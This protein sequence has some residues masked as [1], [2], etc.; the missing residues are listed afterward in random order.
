MKLVLLLKSNVKGHYRTTKSG[1]RVFVK[2][3]D[4][5]RVRHEKA[6]KKTKEIA[7]QMLAKITKEGMVEIPA[8]PS[9]AIEEAI[10][11]FEKT[12]RYEKSEV[13]GKSYLG[14]KQVTMFI[15]T[16]MSEAK[17]QGDVENLLYWSD[18]HWMSKRDSMR[19]WSLPKLIHHYNSTNEKNNISVER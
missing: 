15:A 16:R 6:P 4:D 14:P 12:G 18:L 2:P 5:S 17:G 11:I 7:S 19:K 1:K 3:H 8:N 10:S 9:S 13:D